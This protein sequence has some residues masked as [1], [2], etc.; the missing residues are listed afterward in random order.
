M[1]DQT[2]LPPNGTLEMEETKSQK[3]ATVSKRELSREPSG[4]RREI[5]VRGRKSKSGDRA[6]KGDGSVT[7]VSTVLTLE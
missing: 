7:L 3:I 6:S 2:F 4:Q 5:A 1:S